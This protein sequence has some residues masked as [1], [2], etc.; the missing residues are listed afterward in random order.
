MQR[1]RGNS[2]LDRVIFWGRKI[3]LRDTKLVGEKFEISF[4]KIMKP[5]CCDWYFAVVNG[6]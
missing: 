2:A 6:K 5:L 1:F 3:I 4:A